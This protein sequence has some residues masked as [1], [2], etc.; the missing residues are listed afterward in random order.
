MKVIPLCFFFFLFDGGG[1]RLPLRGRGRGL[2][3]GYWSFVLF[4]LFAFDVQ[5][6]GVFGDY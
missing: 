3:K 5:R 4:M 2:E 6:I 1:L